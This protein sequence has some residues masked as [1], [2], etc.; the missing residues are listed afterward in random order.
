MKQFKETSEV[1]ISPA[2]EFSKTSAFENTKSDV[3]APVHIKT[4]NE[5]LEGQK[6][7][8]T[9][10]LYKKHSFMLDGQKVE[11]V[12]PVFDSKFDVRLPKDTRDSSRGDHAAYATEKLKKK[13]ESDPEFAKQFTPRQIEQIKAGSP[14]ISGFTWHHNEIPG[15]MQLVDSQEHQTC[16]HTG[17]YV[18]WGKVAGKAAETTV[19]ILLAKKGKFGPAADTIAITAGHTVEKVVN[20]VGSKIE[21]RKYK[22]ET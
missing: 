20:G 19:R 8:G 6:Y 14:K 17:G 22:E 1:K 12:F 7:P 2:N 3:K 5:K 15:K 10:V 21:E 16:R 11:G 18:I 4:I 13:I 9:D